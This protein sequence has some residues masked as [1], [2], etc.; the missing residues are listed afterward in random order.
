[1]EEYLKS[2][3]RLLDQPNESWINSG[4]TEREGDGQEETLWEPS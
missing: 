4:G 3:C 1:M 2:E